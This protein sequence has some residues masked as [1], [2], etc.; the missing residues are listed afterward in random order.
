MPSSLFHNLLKVGFFRLKKEEVI[1]YWNVAKMFLE[2][3]I[4]CLKCYFFLVSQKLKS[5]QFGMFSHY[6]KDLQLEIPP[7][8]KNFGEL[9]THP[10]NIFNLK[11]PLTLF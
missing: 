1:K 9:N 8:I 5:F 11:H 2:L 6:I 3:C 10:T 4:V 7:T